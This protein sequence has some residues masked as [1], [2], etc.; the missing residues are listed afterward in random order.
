MKPGSQAGCKGPDSFRIR[1][2]FLQ[3]S[4]FFRYLRITQI[5]HILV[6]E[7]LFRKALA[8]VLMIVFFLTEFTHPA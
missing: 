6:I 8:R 4:G 2:A 3:S 5:I 7:R 1:L